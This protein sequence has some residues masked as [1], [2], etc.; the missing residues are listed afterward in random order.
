MFEPHTRDFGE[1]KQ[2]E[3][4]RVA[5]PC[6]LL[7]RESGLIRFTMLVKFAAESAWGRERPRDGRLGFYGKCG[8][9]FATGGGFISG[10]RG[11]ASIFRAFPR[12]LWGAVCGCFGSD[13]SG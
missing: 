6:R 1:E 2:S 8:F 7:K 9:H 3:S 4:E 12:T 10:C 11:F 5:R 13:V